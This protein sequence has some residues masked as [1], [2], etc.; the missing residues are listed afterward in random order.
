MQQMTRLAVAVGAVAGLT[1]ALPSPA[2]QARQPQAMRTAPAAY[3]GVGGGL[4][5]ANF[6]DSDFDLAGQANANGIGGG[7]VTQTTSRSTN[8]FG[9]KV[10]A[11]Y[12]LNPWFGVELGYT[13]FGKQEYRFDFFQGGAQVGD[14]KMDYEVQSVNLVAVPRYPFPN[15]AFVQGKLGAAFTR[16]ENSFNVNVAG[17]PP[18]GSDKKSRTN[19]LAGIGLGYDFPNGLSIVGEYEY[20]G[21]VGEPINLNATDGIRGTGRADMNLWSVSGMIRF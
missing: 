1:T 3:F 16:T 10:F 6:Q 11:G 13:N 5:Y 7:G 12:R 18:S 17:F 4:A 21:K 8:D 15:G 9:W 19:V 20:Y 14:A 2:Q